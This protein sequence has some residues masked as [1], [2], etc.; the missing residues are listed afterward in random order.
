M[1][2]IQSLVPPVYE[3][4]EFC[5]TRFILEFGRVDV[6]VMNWNL[7]DQLCVEEDGGTG[8]ESGSL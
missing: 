1:G 3:L 8:L 4:L 2:H 7:V 5:P 6:Q